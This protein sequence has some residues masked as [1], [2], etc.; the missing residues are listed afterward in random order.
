MKDS[1]LWKVF[2]EYIRRRDADKDGNCKCFTCNLVRN[3]KQMDCGHGIPRQHKATKF[4]EINNHAQCKRC[5][6]FEGGK[7]EVY[8][9]EVDKRYGPGTWDKLELASKITLKRTQFEIDTMTEFYKQEL[10]KLKHS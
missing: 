9:V 8:K 2:S 6:G 10:K 3:W 5:N 7:R 1:K 4:S